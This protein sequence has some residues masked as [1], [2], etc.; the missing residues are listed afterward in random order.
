MNSTDINYQINYGSFG[1]APAPARVDPNAPL[2]ASEAGVVASLSNSECIFQVRRSGDTH[3]MTFQVL[4]ALD[5]S[6]EFRSLDEHVARI[7][8]TVPGLQSQ[9]EGVVRVLDGLTQRGLL[10]SDRDFLQRAAAGASR[11][12]APLRAVFIRACDRP[13]QLAHLLDSLAEYERRFRANRHY[14]LLD[15]SSTREATNRHR[16]LLREFARA[17]GCKLSYI[18]ASECER[19]VAKIARAVPQAAAR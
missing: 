1:A 4:Q 10:V 17:T 8:A 19:L 14:V 6:R 12:P 2:Y 16:D 9:R 3:V 5:Q 11:E 13:D 7:L 15:D 18:G